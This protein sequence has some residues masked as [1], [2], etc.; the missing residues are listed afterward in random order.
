MSIEVSIEGNDAPDGASPPPLDLDGMPL[1]PT[2]GHTFAETLAAWVGETHDLPPANMREES[3]QALVRHV[4]MHVPKK[5]RARHGV[6]MGLLGD[7]VA[8]VTR[9]PMHAEARAHMARMVSEA[10]PRWTLW[11]LSKAVT[12]GAGIGQQ[13]ETD[14]RALTKYA[15]AVLRSEREAS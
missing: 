10:G 2:E 4:D 3:Y 1:Q 5:H 13:Y 14:S 6:M 15:M 11:A 9:V 8:D 7:Y 12:A